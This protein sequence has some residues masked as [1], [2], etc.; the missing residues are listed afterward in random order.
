VDAL[1]GRYH[2]THFSLEESLEMIEQLQPKRAYL[3]HISHELEYE[4]T[5]EQLPDNVALAYDGLR[6]P[7][8]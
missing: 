6:L 8:T 3:T 2:P 7:L 1:R 5:S 4:K